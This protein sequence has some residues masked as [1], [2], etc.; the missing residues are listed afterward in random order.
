MDED[1][2]FMGK[3]AKCKG[4]AV[5]EACHALHLLTTDTGPQDMFG[6]YTQVGCHGII[7]II[8]ITDILSRPTRAAPAGL[9]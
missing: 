3:S 4:R 8:I 6:P 5:R 2:K 7:I 1:G 9:T